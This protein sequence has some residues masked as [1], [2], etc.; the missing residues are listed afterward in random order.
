MIINNRRGKLVIRAMAGQITRRLNP[1][2]EEIERKRAELAALRL[3]LAEREL[4]I[5][6]VRRQLGAFEGRYLR[7]VGVLYAELDEWNARIAE[8][9][10][11]Q[12]P[13]SEAQQKAE[14]A[15]EHASQTWQ[16]THGEAASASEFNPSPELKRL[17]REV[18]RRIHPDFASNPADLERRTRLM[19]EANRAYQAGDADALRRILDEYQDGADAIS[20][21][22]AGAE[23]IRLIRQISQARARIAAIERELAAL[24]QSEIARLFQDEQEAKLEGRDLLAE[25]ADSV[26]D[27]I[28]IARIEHDALAAEIGRQ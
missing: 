26:R 11:R 18:A 7:Q 20:G 16:D 25:L 21:E 9:R 8:L 23:L 2:E 28:R 10:A 19:A 14:A 22:G 17:F 12:N 24:R 6:D 5:A 15:R 4:E 1:E 3:T 27:R 13:S